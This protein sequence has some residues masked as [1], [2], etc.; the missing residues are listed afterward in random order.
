[1]DWDSNSNFRCTHVERT[2]TKW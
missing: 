1:M 2:W